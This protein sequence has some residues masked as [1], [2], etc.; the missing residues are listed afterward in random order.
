[1]SYD[2]DRPIDGWREDLLD[3]RCFSQEFGK[4]L[5]EY[6]GADGLVVGLYGKWGSGKTSVLNMAKEE[7]YN[8]VSYTHLRAHET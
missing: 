1:M 2:E 5:Y 3:R 7:I 6:N 4:A 8:P